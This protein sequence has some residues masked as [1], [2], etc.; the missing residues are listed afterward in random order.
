MARDLRL[1]IS[2]YAF[3][4]YLFRPH[5]RPL[6]RWRGVTFYF[7]FQKNPDVSFQRIALTDDVASHD[8]PAYLLLSFNKIQIL[9]I[10]FACKQNAYKTR[11]HHHATCYPSGCGIIVQ[12]VF[13]AQPLKE[14]Q[15]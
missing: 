7:S 10:G 6:S 4:G 2:A 8:H 12:N 3:Q 1:I 15:H 5:P 14:Q 13:T 11:N 9:A